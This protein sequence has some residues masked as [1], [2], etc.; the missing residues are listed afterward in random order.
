MAELP[1]DRLRQWGVEAVLVDVDCTLKRYGEDR[2]TAEA[3][4][5]LE[6]LRAAGMGVCLVSN[7]VGW[8]IG[9][10]A[11]QL[12]LPYVAQALKPLPI[13]C[14]GAVRQMG[15]HR[16]RTA[17]IGDQLF[18]DVWAGR[19]AGLKTI[20]VEPIGPE[21]EPWFTRLKRPLERWMLGRL[22]RDR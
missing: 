14:L 10:L 17:M 1:A 9:R 19:L 21:E 2:V 4:A 5:W 8:R 15:F 13:G 16:A 7:G 3:A 20:L 18:A 12:N 6:G 11:E 22:L